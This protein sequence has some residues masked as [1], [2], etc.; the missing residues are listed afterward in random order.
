MA[1]LDLV[2]SSSSAT[3][4]TNE[5]SNYAVFVSFRGED[6]RYNFVGFLY[7]ALKDRGINVFMDNE[8]LRIGEAIGPALHRAIEGS[9]ISIPVLSKTYADSKWCLLELAQIVQCHRANGQMILPI[10]YQIDPSHVR[11]QIGS[12]AEAFDKH[13]KRFEHHVIESWRDGLREVGNLKGEVLDNTKDQAKLVESVVK[14]VMSE[15]FSTTLLAECKYPIGMESHINNLLSLFK[16]DSNDVEIVGICGFGGIGKTTIAK[17][18]YNRILSKFNKHSFISNV[19]DQATEY[20]GLVSL[21]NRLLKDILK[22]EAIDVGDI[23]RG[24]E[25]IKQ[26]L[27]NKKVLLVL[28]DVDSQEQIQ[29]LVGEFDWFGNGS[30]V[31]ITTRDL[32]ILNEAKVVED[33]IY[34]PQKL[35]PKQSLQLFSWHAFTLNQP[36]EDYEQISNDM[37]GYSGGLPL[38]LEVLGSY[39][40][41]IRNKEVWKSTLQKLKEI[42]HKKVQDQLKISYD[43]LEND[44][45]KAMFLD[46]ACLFVGWEK[47]TVISIWEASGYIPNSEMHILIRR[48]L[49]KFEHTWYD[50]KCYYL[51]MHDQIRDMGRNI[52]REESPIELGKRSRLWSYGDISKVLKEHKG[53]GMI[54]GFAHPS[55]ICHF[56]AKDFEMMPNLRFFYAHSAN[57]GRDFSCLPVELKWFKWNSCPIPPTN[58]CHEKLVYLDLSHSDFKRAWNVKSRDKNK[59][60]LELKVLDLSKCRFLSKSPDFSWFPY[61]ERLNLGE[62]ISLDKLDESIGQLTLL[63]NL[64]LSECWRIKE[65]PKSIGDLKSL[66]KLDLS[67]TMIEE[68]PDG[69][70]K[71]S[72]LEELILEFCESLKKLPESIGELKSLVELK[73]H[74]CFEI[75]ELPDSIGSLEKIKI[76]DASGC[77]NLKKPPISMRR[78]RHL[79]SINLKGTR[80][81]RLPNDFSMLPNLVELK[82]SWLLQSFP[83]DLSYLKKLKQLEFCECKKK[84]NLLEHRPSLFELYCPTCYSMVL[85]DLARLK[86]LTKVLPDDCEKLEEIPSLEGTE[87]IEDFDVTGCYNL[88]IIPR[89]I[90][91]QGTLLPNRS[92]GN[93][94]MLLVLEF[95]SVLMGR[96]IELDIS[97]SIHQEDKITRCLLH[98]LKIEDFTVAGRTY[99]SEDKDIIYIHHL[100]GFNWFGI[101]LQE[102]DGIEILYI[103]ASYLNNTKKFRVKFNWSYVGNMLLVSA[104]ST[105]CLIDE[106]QIPFDTI[107]LPAEDEFQIPFDTIQLPAEVEVCSCY[108]CQIFPVHTST[109]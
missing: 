100:N 64:I 73:L 88:A 20:V 93:R 34:F 46:A 50:D 3:A 55:S 13:E 104:P 97:A 31:I 18:A 89:K 75:E 70:S 92:G 77:R 53:T 37:V 69:I 5:S 7:K 47:E 80:T 30:R 40:L 68:L 21:Q 2:S 1:A 6:T 103:S 107:K 79:H 4:S 42:P 67:W 87:P 95:P 72:S 81:S 63:K 60:F 83:A 61:L 28:D 9:R 96:Q 51:R 10:F 62:C 78:M 101:P 26:R 106:F 86:I 43:N 19:R 8:E 52:V 25:L 74:D 54:Q 36:P 23:H 59:R 84:E 99:Y 105:S 98:T 14:K 39:L 33:K 76:L 29:A 22:T 65:L 15:L 48:S 24:K 27:C 41:G 66:V 108:L 71:L 91:E 58:F 57:I 102:D 45:Q 38:T 35:D 11:H 16:E 17:A 85:P 90:N 44:Y 12:F 56:D 94:I 82:M 109:V 32:G 49:L